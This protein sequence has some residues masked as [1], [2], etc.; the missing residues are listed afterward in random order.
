MCGRFGLEYG[1]DFYPRFL[2]KN[3]LPSMASNFNISPGQQVAVIINQDG[4]NILQTMKWGLIPFWAKDPK[5][6]NKLFN[7]RIETIDEK[8]S[9]RDSFHKRRCLIPASFFYEWQEVDG[10]KI[11]HK[12]FLKENKYFAMASI[13]DIWKDPNG[14]SIPTFTIL[15]TTPNDIVKPIHERMPVILDKREEQ[16]WLDPT[17]DL[18]SLKKLVLTPLI[19]ELMVSKI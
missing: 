19:K 18:V 12:F 10:K 17:A 13:Y 14:V 2:L 5:I 6:G 16:K 7:A 15:T 1:K 3:Q 4:S 11:P 9:F 8:P